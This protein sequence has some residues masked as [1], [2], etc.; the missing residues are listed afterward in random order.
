MAKTDGDDGEAADLRDI[1]PANVTTP[2]V[3]MQVSTWCGV[4]FDRGIAGTVWAAAKSGA[5]PLRGA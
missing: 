3:P 5:V 2:G 1:I 4:V